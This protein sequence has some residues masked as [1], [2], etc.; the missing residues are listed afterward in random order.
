MLKKENIKISD[1]S[2]QLISQSDSSMI[3]KISDGRIAK[4]ISPL[5]TLLYSTFGIDFYKKLDAMQVMQGI[6]G[7]C[8]PESAIVT[9][10]GCIGY[11]MQSVSGR[12]FNERDDELTYKDRADLHKYIEL[13]KKINELVKK[14]NEV[15]VVFPDLLTCDNFIIGEDESV[16]MIDIDGAQVLDY[17]ALAMSTSLGREDQYIGSK[18]YMRDLKKCLWTSELDKKSLLYL[19]FLDVLNGDLNKIGEYDPVNRRKITLDG[20]LRMYGLDDIK[21]QK[22]IRNILSEYVNGQYLDEFYKIIEKKYDLQAIPM[23][24]IILDKG[25]VSDFLS[26]E[27]MNRMCIKKLIRK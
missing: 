11:T 7:I 18:K 22:M 12:T 21:I 8:L 25:K 20:I 17:P 15:G 9:E 13:H 1:S 24:R 10:Q 27:E 2:L 4:F 3:F 23:N 6:D 14:C 19:F 16:S 26:P 5:S